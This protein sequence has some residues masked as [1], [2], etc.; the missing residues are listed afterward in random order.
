MLD[1]FADEL[2]AGSPATQGVHFKPLNGP[3]PNGRRPEHVTCML[4]YA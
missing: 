2:E 3:G 4:R 1:D